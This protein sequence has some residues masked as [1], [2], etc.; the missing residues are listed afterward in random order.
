M[1][2]FLKSSASTTIE[3]TKCTT[4]IIIFVSFCAGCSK[5]DF[6][7]TSGNDGNGL[8]E[9]C[10]KNY[11]NPNLPTTWQPWDWNGYQKFP[12]LYLAAEPEGFFN[13]EQMQKISRFS[14]AILEFRMGQFAEEFSTGKWAGGDLA[15]FMETQVKNFKAAHPNGPPMLV[16]RSG[17]WAGSM[18]EEQWNALQNQTLFIEDERHCQGFISYPMDV[19]ESGFETDLKYCRWDFRKCETQSVFKDL[20]ED[21]AM[22]HSDGVFFDN[23]QSVPCDEGNELSYM[24]YEERKS[25][26]Q[27]Q[28]EL[29]AEVFSVLVNNNKYPILSTT[30][31]FSDIGAQVPWENDCPLAEEAIIEALEGIPFARNNEFWMWNLGETAARQIRNSIKETQNGIPIIVHMPYFPDDGGCLDGCIQ[32]DGTKKS[33]TKDEFL[34]FGIAA[35]LVSMGPGSYFGFSN[36]QNDPELG[37]WGDVSWEYHSQYDTI[38]TGNPIGEVQLSND[39]MTFTREFDNG[40]V[41]VNCAD[42]TYSIGLQ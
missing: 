5:A 37:G 8:S 14:L 32:L 27:S 38:E 24:T 40:T 23:A 7:E 11:E 1:H 39:G 6:E 18:Y 15:G 13:A 4:F 29:Y 34:E 31:G 35:F 12:S 25:F 36:M 16:Y 19:D 30:N 3:W 28:L 17:M 41:W 26:M 33:F 22:G 10:N 9:G 42:G 21:V 2:I 20:I